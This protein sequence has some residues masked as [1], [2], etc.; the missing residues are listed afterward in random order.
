L[1]GLFG[2]DVFNGR[3][4]RITD[5]KG[6]TILPGVW[7]SLLEPNMT[8]IVDTCAYVPENSTI[9][10]APNL[11]LG[12]KVSNPNFDN[13]HH[14]W[15]ATEFIPDN[16]ETED[17]CYGHANEISPLG[18][19]GMAAAMAPPNSLKKRPSPPPPPPPSN[20]DLQ[21]NN[22]RFTSV[23]MFTGK[24]SDQRKYDHSIT[25]KPLVIQKAKPEIPAKK[26]IT[27]QRGEWENTEKPKKSGWGKVARALQFVF[28][29]GHANNF[30]TRNQKGFQKEEFGKQRWHMH[31]PQTPGTP[32]SVMIGRPATAG[33]RRPTT[34]HRQCAP[35]FSPPRRSATLHRR[36][37][38]LG[39]F[40]LPA[41]A[42]IP[43][44]IPQLIHPT[45]P[46]PPTR[47]PSNKIKR[48]QSERRVRG[49]P[50][51]LARSASLNHGNG[52]ISP[53][54]PPRPTVGLGVSAQ[55]VL[56]GEHDL[57]QLKEL[58]DTLDGNSSL[59]TGSMSSR[60]GT[61]STQATTVDDVRSLPLPL[62]NKI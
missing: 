4:V 3:R 27:V 53:P 18:Q 36:S 17:A 35:S 7:K 10:F 55:F 6:C 30:Q 28:S 32:P 40:S 49:L 48:S 23:S 11:G 22:K 21:E 58:R 59:G 51:T 39:N 13:N 57:E 29:A 52:V 1:A 62:W 37:R 60:R 15:G 19:V 43:Q 14:L 45:P 5:A 50:K 61:A 31:S 34:A 42:P 41:A 8:I 46:N 2:T 54:I 9:M 56:A 33:A 47:R 12:K 38:S 26:S 20:E 24:R 25:V 44:P 16:Q